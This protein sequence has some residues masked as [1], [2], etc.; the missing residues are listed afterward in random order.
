MNKDYIVY[1]IGGIVLGLVL[2]FYSANWFGP[3]PIPGAQAASTGAPKSTSVNNPSVGSQDLPP[4]H[5]PID[6]GQ[7]VPAPPLPDTSAAS[8]AAPSP[9]AGAGEP[10]Q[11]PSLDPLPASS[12]EERAE[13]KYKNIQMLKGLPADRLMSVMFAFKSS[14][15]VD[16]TYC[17]IKDQFEKDDKPPKQVARKMITLV[18]DTNA[19]LGG[20]ARVTCFTCH[21]GQTRPAS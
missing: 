16:C 1:G 9:T 20:A 10:T 12:R 18:R 15:G 21:R 13:Q 4:N 6:S 2:G 11:L 5:P 17:H 19:K 14:L 7:T 3:K 8:G